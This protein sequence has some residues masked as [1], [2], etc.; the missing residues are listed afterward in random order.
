[1]SQVEM[2]AWKLKFM[3][4]MALKVLIPGIPKLRKNIPVELPAGFEQEYIAALKSGDL[5]TAVSSHGS[6]ANALGAMNLSTMMWEIAHDAKLD[7][8]TSIMLPV[9]ASLL[10][11]DQD[12]TLKKMGDALKMQV[13]AAHI[14]PIA[15]V[16]KAADL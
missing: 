13:E 4:F 1:M 14:E 9:A 8:P 6:H 10:S 5:A 16:E 7:Y 12:P 3:E 15:T 2:S 11:G